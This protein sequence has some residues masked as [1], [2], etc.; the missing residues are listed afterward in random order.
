MA[1]ATALHSIVPEIVEPEVRGKM[2]AELVRIAKGEKH[3]EEVVEYIKKNFLAYYD[4][5]V[6]NSNV[7]AEK[8]VE[9]LKRVYW[10]GEL[11]KS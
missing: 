4:K 1:L 11:K 10:S 5:L 7:L 6:S 2:E 8:L 3:P 9:A